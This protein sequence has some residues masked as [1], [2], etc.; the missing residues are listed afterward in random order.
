M[1]LTSADA[2][3]FGFAPHLPV[4]HPESRVERAHEIYEQNRHRAYSLAFLMTDNELV[5]EELM[6]QAFC[7]AFGTSD[8]PAAE[9]IDRALISELRDYTFSDLRTPTLYCSPCNRVLSVRRNVLRVDLE[10]AIVQLPDTEKL[11]F[12]LHDVE[13]Y[14][15]SRIARLLGVP[16][17]ESR[18][19]V[20]QARL[21]MR[22]LLEK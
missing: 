13:G 5:A 14:D 2:K 11:M 22:E 3:M 20:H 12:L 4:I 21:R 10:R 6:M 1:S 17:D 18:R 19:G 7:H 15:H 16:E 9:D 8:Q